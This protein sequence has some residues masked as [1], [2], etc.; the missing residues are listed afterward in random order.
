[1]TWIIDSG[2]SRH[3][4]GTSKWFQNLKQ[5]EQGNVTLGDKTKKKVISKGMVKI[6]NNVC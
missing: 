1:M 2:C 3:M 4:T 6:S 5:K